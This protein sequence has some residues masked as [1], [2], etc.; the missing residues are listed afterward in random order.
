MCDYLGNNKTEVLPIK[1]TTG[2]AIV[3]IGPYS[4]FSPFSCGVYTEKDDAPY[5]NLE[6]IFIPSNYKL[7]RNSFEGNKKIKNVFFESDN[8]YAHEWTVFKDCSSLEGVVLPSSM[9]TVPF[10]MFDGCKSIKKIVLPEELMSVDKYAFRGTSI[11][12][13]VVPKSV[14]VIKDEAFASQ[15]L[16]DVYVMSKTT[17]LDITWLAAEGLQWSSLSLHGYK[18]STLHDYWKLSEEED[19]NVKMV[20]L[21]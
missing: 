6:N 15:K 4:S 5:S 8:G 19:L 17:D 14:K 13:L 21:D 3:E 18:N 16:R 2:R 1:L 20:F 9:S 10:A 11:S 12:K 7:W